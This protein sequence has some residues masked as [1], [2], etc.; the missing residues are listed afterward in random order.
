MF[1]IIDAETEVLDSPGEYMNGQQLAYFKG[2]LERERQAV[3][4]VLHATELPENEGAP[5]W[6]DQAVVE[7]DRRTEAMVLDRAHTQLREID[8]ALHRIEDGSYGYCVDTGE[9]IG[10]A[11]LL[12]RPTASLTVEA[13]TQ[14]EV[15]EKQRGY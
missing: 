11:R 8:A 15:R 7:Q 3:L 1:E 10:L 5:D 13:Q 9:E 14:R 12:A 6:L 2:L 4:S